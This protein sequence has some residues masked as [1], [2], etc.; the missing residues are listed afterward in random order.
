MNPSP[1]PLP[2]LTQSFSHILRPFFFLFVRILSAQSFISWHVVR[3]VCLPACLPACL[4]FPLT[5]NAYTS[6]A[7]RNIYQYQRF[8]LSHTPIHSLI[9]AEKNKDRKGYITHHTHDQDHT[10]TQCIHTHTHT[11]T[12]IYI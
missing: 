8:S 2:L 5:L 4:F 3:A 9:R 12:Y 11:H 1:L 7:C 6:C 10:C